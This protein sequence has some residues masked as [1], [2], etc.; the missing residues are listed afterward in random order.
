MRE[1]EL[2]APAGG[3]ESLIAAVQAGCDAVYLG[4]DA[5]GARAFAGNFDREQMAEAIRYAH[6][7]GV[8][9]YVTMNTLIYEDEMEAALAY[10]RFLY[11]HDA[12]ALLLQDIGLCDRIRQE[13]PDFELH[14]STQMHIHNEAGME[15]ARRL[16][17]SRVVLPRE[18]T[19]EEIR[20]LSGQGMEIEVFVHGA[21]CVCYS[22]QCL[23]SASLMGRSGNRGEC[24]QPCRMRYELYREEM[25]GAN[26]IPAQGAYLLS[27][28]DL[29]TLHEL[30]AL[31]DAGVSSLK[32]EGRMKKPEYV[33]QVVSMYRAAIDAWKQK[34]QLPQDVQKEWDL[35]KLFNRGFTKGHA[36]HASGRAMMNP[37]RPN[38]QGVV[39][40]E[41]IAVSDRRITIRLSEDLHQGDGIRILGKE[42]DAGCIV[43]RLYKDG[44]LVAHAKKGEVVAIDRKIPAR[45]HAEV[46]RTSDSELQQQLRRTYAD[47]RKVKVSVH[48]TLQVGKGLVCRMRDEEGFCV[49]RTGE[50]VIQPAKNAPIREETLHRSFAQ[51]GDTPLELTDF[52]VS[53][54]EDCFLSVASIKQV[55]RQCAEALLAQ[56]EHRHPHR[57]YGTYHRTWQKSERPLGVF[58]CVQTQEQ[59]DACRQAGIS[60]IVTDRESLYARLQAAQEPILF[61]EGN[62]VKKRGPAQMGGENGALST[63]RTIVDSTL[64]IT[65]RAAA[66][67]VRACGSSTMVLSLEHDRQSLQALCDAFRKEDSDLPDL[68]IQLYGYRDLMTSRTCVINTTLKDGTKSGC[69]LCRRHRY[70]LKDQKDRRFFL[71]NDERCHMRILSETADDHIDDLALYQ[72]M[73]ISSFYLRFT[74]ESKAQTEAVLARVRKACP[75]EK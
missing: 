24:A 53:M 58:A 11:E 50:E 48:L 59:Y 62:I 55:R 10:A 21:L 4:G 22:G 33:A 66:A 18:S 60:C 40:G 6:R 14:A 34:R 29:F 45:R 41:V 49:E 38:H 51:L 17:I 30:D 13:L 25:Q 23:M 47:C 75:F 27:P 56:R 43:N 16:G 20:S 15:T 57:R 42:E 63:G 72:H 3:M 31:L 67:Y 26:K 28:K 70:F 44:K 5:F 2:L 39:L 8:R 74:I 35:R 9:V 71:N 64:N 61:H 73:G 36:F 19:I 65:N 7:Y 1:V 69:S 68:A 32:I 46:R 52:H 54:N 12:D 37:I